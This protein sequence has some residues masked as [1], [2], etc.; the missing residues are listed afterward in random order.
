M[1]CKFKCIIKLI[2]PL[3]AKMHLFSIVLTKTIF[4]TYKIIQ[5]KIGKIKNNQNQKVTIS[6]IDIFKIDETVEM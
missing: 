5:S 4:T 2:N 6:M 1:A 3:I